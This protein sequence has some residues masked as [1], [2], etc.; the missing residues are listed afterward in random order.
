MST[1]V[2]LFLGEYAT[3]AGTVIVHIYREMHDSNRPWVEVGLETGERAVDVIT[4]P[5]PEGDA[6]WNRLRP[7]LAEHL[8]PEGFIQNE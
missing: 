2:S 8:P 5:L 4:A 3:Q 1:R 7:W 6:D